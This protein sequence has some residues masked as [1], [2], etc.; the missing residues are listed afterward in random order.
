MAFIKSELLELLQANVAALEADYISFRRACDQQR[1]EEALS[2]LAALN[3]IRKSAHLS[4]L[5]AFNAK[6]SAIRA[7]ECG[8]ESG[9]LTDELRRISDEIGQSSKLI[10]GNIS[11]Q[12]A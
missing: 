2:V 5:V 3:Q 12:V 7:G 10:V 1:E 6:I 9:A 11:T 8:R 4:R